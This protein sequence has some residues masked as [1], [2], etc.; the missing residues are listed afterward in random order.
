MQSTLLAVFL[1]EQLKELR[2]TEV[3]ELLEDVGK[4]EVLTLTQSEL[5]NPV[6]KVD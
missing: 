5:R 6:E 2:E 4:V 3:T 1:E